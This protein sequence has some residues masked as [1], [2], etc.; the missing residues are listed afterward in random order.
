MAE[1]KSA[2]TEMPSGGHKEA[3]PPFNKETFASQLLWL[4]ITFVALYL[5]MSRIALPRVSGIIDARQK[6]IADDLAAAQGLK[7]ESEKAL[8][9]YEKKLAEARANAQTIAGKTRDELTA[10]ANERRKIT[11]ERLNK[12]LEEAEKTIAAT[13]QA[14]MANVQAIATEAAAAIVQ[15]LIGSVPSEKSISEAVAVALKR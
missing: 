15:R 8:A 5:M 1:T 2:H 9:A 14:A 4:V 7:E 11:E 6:R 3:F 12:R 13:K 10:K